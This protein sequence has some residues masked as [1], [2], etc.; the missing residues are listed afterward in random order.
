LKNDDNVLD[1]LSKIGIRNV[2]GFEKKENDLINY[3]AN[4][5]I[6]EKN[7][8]VIG[9]FRAKLNEI[10]VM[11]HIKAHFSL[12]SGSLCVSQ[13]VLTDVDVINLFEYATSRSGTVNKQKV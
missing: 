9:Q 4:Y 13:K 7:L 1:L 3:I 2:N 10:G 11:S 12:W 6:Y 5:V 8:Q